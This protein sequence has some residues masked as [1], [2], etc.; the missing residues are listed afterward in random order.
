MLNKAGQYLGSLLKAYPHTRIVAAAA[1][2]Y[3]DGLTS[4]GFIPVTMSA[5]ENQQKNDFLN[6]WSELWTRHIRRSLNQEEEIDPLLLNSWLEGGE[7]NPNPLE[8][9]LKVWGAYSG[10]LLGVKSTDLIETH[11]LRLTTHLPEVKTH[12]ENIATQMMTGMS[13]ALNLKELDRLEAETG[14]E[15]MA[16]QAHAWHE[17]ESLSPSSEVEAAQEQSTLN[18]QGSL[19]PTGAKTSGSSSQTRVMSDLIANGLLVA[20][21]NGKVSFTHPIFAFYLAGSALAAAGLVER[22]VQQPEWTGKTNTLRYLASWND[23]TEYVLPVLEQKDD[24]LFRRMIS[25]WRWLPDAP[26]YARWRTAAMRKIAAMIQQELLP[27]GLR[28]RAIA[29]L[30]LSKDPGAV[31]LFKQFLS[32]NSET[33]RQLAALGSGLIKDTKSVPELTALLDDLCLPVSRAGILA[34]GAIGNR[35]ALDTIAATLL[36]GREEMR[37][38]AA[39]ILSTLPEEGHPALLEGAAMDDLLVR[40]AVVY[41]LALTREQWAIR[42]LEKMQ[43]EDGQWVVRTAATQALEELAQPN[44]HIP[45]PLPALTQAPWLIMFAGKLGMGVSPGKPARDLVAQVLK[46]GEPEERLAA[47]EYVALY[48]DETFIPD[49]YHILYGCEGELREAAFNAL[50]YLGGKGVPFPS[51]TQ[52]GLG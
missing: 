16:N 44:P 19:K 8:L 12:L 15:D 1:Y 32:H 3:H 36:T 10:D 42:I 47:L 5:W 21:K 6:R 40:R 20:R 27:V 23:I 22:Y 48:G 37:R 29:A 9:T 50:F 34:L 13:L 18:N 43:I 33:V 2:E 26:K 24:P 49:I 45:H 51:P 31:V 30:A 35:A 28:G 39:E 7:G 4:S 38:A 25:T 52:F 41:G 14:S 11:L 46:S 17:A